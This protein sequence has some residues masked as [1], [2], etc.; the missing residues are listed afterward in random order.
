MHYLQMTDLIL[1]IY[2]ITKKKTRRLSKTISS[3]HFNYYIPTTIY[4]A[5]EIS[6][7]YIK[8]CEDFPMILNA[9]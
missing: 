1:L 8:N 5:Y 7:F 2:N 6:L 9:R 3:K 4:L